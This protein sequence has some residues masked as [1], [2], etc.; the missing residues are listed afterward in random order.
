MS[1]PW[2]RR[3]AASRSHPCPRLG[4]HGP[5]GGRYRPC[6]DTLED[7]TVPS[8]IA[9]LTEANT[10]VLFDATTPG[11]VLGEQPLTGLQPGEALVG[12]DVRPATGELY[13]LGN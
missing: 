10:L 12:I 5:R 13:G 11:T 4:R 8:T 1:S 9:G 7:R 2:Y 6:F 3:L